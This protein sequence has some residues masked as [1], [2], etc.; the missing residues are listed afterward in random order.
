MSEYNDNYSL[1]E[2]KIFFEG[3][4]FFLIDC[5]LGYNVPYNEEVVRY[6]L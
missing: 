5:N 1:D 6:V 2:V 4:K 3:M